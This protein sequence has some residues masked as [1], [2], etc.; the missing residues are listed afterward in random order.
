MA[1]RG[2]SPRLTA[3]MLHRTTDEHTPMKR[4]MSRK[5][6]RF[7][8]SGQDSHT[9]EPR[10]LLTAVN[11]GSLTEV[12][13]L[14]NHAG[15][16]IGHTVA[17]PTR[18]LVFVGVQAATTHAATNHPAAIKTP[19]TALAAQRLATNPALTPHSGPFKD[20][21]TGLTFYRSRSTGHTTG[22]PALKSSTTRA[23]VPSLTAQ[24]VATTGSSS[25]AS[26][27][28]ARFEA[29][30]LSPNAA[31][32]TSLATSIE[33][34]TPS[35]TKVNGGKNNT[36]TATVTTTGYPN[37]TVLD[38]TVI[39][40]NYGPPQTSETTTG[41]VTINNNTG[42]VSISSKTPAGTTG[43]TGQVQVEVNDPDSADADNNETNI[44]YN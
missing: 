34:G 2:T 35:P 13:P 3:F 24:S 30:A 42:S 18:A 8:L 26:R 6:R 36:V 38:V 17:L 16:T 14:P 22:Q 25:V 44:T 41:T 23:I 39:I 5:P 20:T 29:T 28:T 9:L 31:S 32:A 1:S 33:V 40:Y 11:V 10:H 19:V 7:T 27:P 43:N 21:A 37:G 15:L 4:A 12:L